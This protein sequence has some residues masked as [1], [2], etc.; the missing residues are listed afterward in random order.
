MAEGFTVGLTA[1]SGATA[2]VEQAVGHYRSLADALEGDLTSVR[3]TTS[4]TGGFGA[5]GHFQ[6]LLAEFSH[7]WLATMA[8][9]VKE[10]RAFVTFLEGFAK[11]LEQTRGEYQSTEA[12]HAEVF[13]NIS[14][15]IGER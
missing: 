10:E 7:E 9:F 11:R 8:E 6:G 13:E 15:S 1:F 12:R 14:R 5:T 4:L 2:A 3:D